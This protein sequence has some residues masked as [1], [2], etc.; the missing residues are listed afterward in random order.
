MHVQFVICRI[1]AAFLLAGFVSACSNANWSSVH[2][3][4]QISED[5][6]LNSVLIDAKQSA[7]LTFERP[8]N[9]HWYFAGWPD[10]VVVDEVYGNYERAVRGTVTS[11]CAEPS[12]D[13]LAAV[14]ANFAA[15]LNGSIAGEGSG[16]AA[17]G[18]AL[19]EA[20]GE[21]GKRN[22][23]I[24]MLRDGFYRLCEGWA[25]GYVDEFTYQ[26]HANKLTNAMVVL[27]AV[28]EL[29]PETTSSGTSIEVTSSGS[30]TVEIDTTADTNVQEPDAAANDDGSTAEQTAAETQ[31]DN[32]DISVPEG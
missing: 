3:E 6:G 7:I 29:T 19:A 2:R 11:F 10:E 4:Y 30:S 32:D 26:Q 21:L 1:A 17:F 28:E 9:G 16:S 15:S 12:P 22:A 14:S 23:T 31:T 25:N 18:I 13:A 5:D 20:V 8:A 27:L 24:A